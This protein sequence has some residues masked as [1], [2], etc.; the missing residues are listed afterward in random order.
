MKPA[1]DPKVD[2]KDLVR[3]SYNRC[4]A[5]YDQTRQQKAE[6]TLAL[7]INRLHEGAAVLDVGCGAGVP[8]AR[9]LSQRFSVTGVDMAETMIDRARQN[10]PAATFI[11]KDIMLVDFPPSHFDAV[12]AFYS[13]F[14]LPREEH[15]ELFRRIYR[16][17]KPAGYFIGTLSFW[18][19]AAYTEDD[20]FGVTMYWS[21]YSLDE[22]K[23][24]LEGIGFNLLETTIIGHGP[25]ERHPLVFAQKSG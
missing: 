18:N 13:I 6:P 4:G 17:L 20:F 15:T 25:D 24:I 23:Q 16:W 11:H 10:V 5:A 12:V 7:L 22:Y 9:E 8:V 14:H 1:D 21:N 19:E 2:Y 3:R